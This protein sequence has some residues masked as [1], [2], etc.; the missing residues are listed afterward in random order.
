MDVRRLDDW[1]GDWT[2]RTLADPE[3]ADAIAAV[4]RRLSARRAEL[5]GEQADIEATLIQIERPAGR[6]EI[7]LPRHDAICGPLEARL[8]ELT[9]EL[10]DLAAEEADRAPLPPGTRTIPA[11]DA[12]HVEWLAEWTHGTDAER[13]AMV[14]R[15]LG[16][17]R[18]VVGPGKNARFDPERV[19]VRAS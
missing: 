19:T 7:S 5:L 8:A 3:H 1:A 12:R 4:E 14:R 11:R 13:R 18:I 2:V 6:R 16:G 17:P 10:A 9:A 15:A